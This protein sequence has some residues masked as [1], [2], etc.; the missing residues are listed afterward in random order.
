MQNIVERP[1]SGTPQ[2]FKVVVPQKPGGFADRFD[3]TIEPYL[4]CTFGCDY[5]FVPGQSIVHSEAFMGA[6]GSWYYPTSENIREEIRHNFSTNKTSAIY[7]AS[8]TDAWQPVEKKSLIT[9]SVL[10][11]LRE[12]E[13]SY[14]LCSTRSPLITRDIDVIKALRG[15]VQVGVSIPTNLESV[16]KL[17]EPAAPKIE[18]RI[19]TLKVLKDAGIRVRAHL[20]PLLPHGDDFVARIVDVCDSV[21][22]DY[23][24]SHTPAKEKLF[25]KNGWNDW[26]SKNL[27]EDLF[28]KYQNAFP[29]KVFKFGQKHFFDP[30]STSAGN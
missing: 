17:S 7:L 20:A 13:F 6:W 15:D 16:R 10:C 24:D 26:L 25:I 28:Y 2:P 4:G 5:C 3:F 1:N 11:A 19:K 27:I 21:W 22:I 9:R 29:S 30:L 8:N 18:D 23:P 12:Y 14:L